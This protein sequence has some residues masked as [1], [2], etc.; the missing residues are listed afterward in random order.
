MNE[1]QKWVLLGK[2]L[3]T[4]LKKPLNH[5]EFI[6][7]FIL[8]II[9]VGAIGIYTSVFGESLPDTKNKFII[10]NMAS[11]FLAIIATGTVELIFI[12]EKNIKRAILL[13]SVGAIFL[14]TF[15]FF[16]CI[17]YATYWLAAPGLLIALIVWW[18]ANAENANIIEGT[19]N[20]EIREESN[21]KH[22]KNW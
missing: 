8:V 13:L 10:S 21:D 14:N 1:R 9:G 12:Q 2:F 11:Y 16:L 18:I 7:Y 3:N 22:G 4:R 19:Y 15:L 17:H 6:F 5:P 20:S